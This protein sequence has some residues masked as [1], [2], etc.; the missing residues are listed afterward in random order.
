MGNDII[1]AVRGITDVVIVTNTANIKGHFGDS[2]I[3]DH[4]NSVMMMWCL[5]RG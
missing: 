1:R 3:Q 5:S 2:G 4:C